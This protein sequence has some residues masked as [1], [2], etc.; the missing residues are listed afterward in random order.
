[1][2]DSD[3]TFERFCSS[4]KNMTKIQDRLRQQHRQQHFF[5][6]AQPAAFFS[7]LP[8]RD[9]TRSVSQKK[10]RQHFN[11]IQSIRALQCVWMS[12]WTLPSMAAE[13]PGATVARVQ[14]LHKVQC[15]ITSGKAIFY[16]SIS[17]DH[18]PRR[19]SMLYYRLIQSNLRTQVKRKTDVCFLT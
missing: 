14:R 17:N 16:Q 10:K 15:F 11:C 3:Y 5:S 18:K 12:C 9:L 7:A 4:N 1:M 19:A 2:V 13:E 6:F 8:P